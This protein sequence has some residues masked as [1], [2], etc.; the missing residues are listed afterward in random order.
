MWKLG[1]RDGKRVCPNKSSAYF[2]SS[3]RKGRRS[4]SEMGLPGWRVGRSWKGCENLLAHTVITR[5]APPMGN[6]DP[7][8]AF[9]R[10]LY[11]APPSQCAL[12]LKWVPDVGRKFFYRPK[13]GLNPKT[14]CGYFKASL[15]SDVCSLTIAHLILTKRSCQVIHRGNRGHQV[16]T[17]SF[18][19]V[20]KSTSTHIQPRMS[21]L[22]LVLSGEVSLSYLIG[23]ASVL[24]EASPSL[25]RPVSPT[26]PFMGCC[27]PA[28]ECAG[29]FHTL[30]NA[31]VPH[32]FLQ[33]LSA[34]HF[35][36]LRQ[37]S[38]NSICN[39]YLYFLF[40]YLLFYPLK[41]DFLPPLHHETALAR[42]IHNL[43]VLM[44]TGTSISLGKKSPLGNI[45]NCWQG[46]PSRHTLSW[47]LS[48]FFSY[49]TDCFFAI[50]FFFFLSNPYLEVF[51]RG[52]LFSHSTRFFPRRSPTPS[53]SLMT[54]I[55]SFN[56]CILN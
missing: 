3:Y 30:Y 17:T 15:L 54:T 13:L 47:F 25:L 12:Q 42:V 24:C 40:F 29:G 44:L 46:S 33:L 52:L 16:S 28:F 37:M 23:T 34:V 41:S 21:F 53:C 5:T 32:T 6:L 20:N 36:L 8:N 39:H 2:F 50:F 56:T 43:F 45:E 11:L 35:Q 14:C 38:F 18:C 10:L 4:D 7:S 19:Q 1:L 27:L 31:S 22:S 51:L 48:W 49:L 55:H 26:Q 9:P